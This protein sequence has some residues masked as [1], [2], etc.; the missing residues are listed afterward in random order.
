MSCKK[1]SSG[2]KRRHE[3][4][5]TVNIAAAFG[6]GAFAVLMVA[7]VVFVVRFSRSLGRKSRDR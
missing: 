2:S 1:D 5:D 3:Q 4:K 6:F 7:L